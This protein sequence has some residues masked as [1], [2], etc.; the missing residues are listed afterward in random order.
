MNKS[1]I[2]KHNFQVAK[3]KIEQLSRELPSNPCFDQVEEDAGPFGL[4]DHKVTGEEMNNFIGKVQDK[5]VSVNSS[6][7]SITNGFKEV[8]KAFDFLDSE[9]INGIIGAVE[10]AEDASEKAVQAQSDIK[11]TVEN[12]EKTVKGLVNL[13]QAVKQL[14]EKVDKQKAPISSLS[15]QRTPK[16][17][18]QKFDADRLQKCETKIKIAYFTGGCSVVLSLTSLILQL[19]GVL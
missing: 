4:L 5:L 15:T 12:L 10:S 18:T 13:K 19:L 6:L 16:F 9:Y 3:D 14:E 11:K 1:L 17:S 8:Y 2:K 7:I